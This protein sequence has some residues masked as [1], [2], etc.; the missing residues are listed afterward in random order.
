[1]SSSS[2]AA[3]MTWR[4][5]ET[6]LAPFLCERFA[7]PSVD[8]VGLVRCVGGCGRCCCCCD[9]AKVVTTGVEVLE[10]RA[11]DGGG[12]VSGTWVASILVT[13]LRPLVASSRLVS[14]D[15]EAGRAA[16][17]SPDAVVPG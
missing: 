1:M 17:L 9:S 8:R 15:L 4:M 5:A 10:E 7:G 2:A 13:T 14:L 6:L 16:P 3:A 12:R 11:L